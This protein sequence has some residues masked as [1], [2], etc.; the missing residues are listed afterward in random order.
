[1]IT[2]VEV[3]DADGEPVKVLVRYTVN[4]A[5]P[6]CYRDSNGDGHPGWPRSAEFVSATPCDEWITAWIETHWDDI[7]QEVLENGMA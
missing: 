7:E 1:M 6:A 3:P 5:E 4:E 2:A